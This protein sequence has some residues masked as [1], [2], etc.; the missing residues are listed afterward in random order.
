MLELNKYSAILWET[1]TKL[2]LICVIH[3][4]SSMHLNE[5]Y[6]KLPP[7][8]REGGWGWGSYISLNQ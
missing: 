3:H 4:H 8:L 1:L 7:R 6:L 2:T 5:I